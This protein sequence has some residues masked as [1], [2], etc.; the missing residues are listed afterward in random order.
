[1]FYF[2]INEEMLADTNRFPVSSDHWH[3]IDLPEEMGGFKVAKFSLMDNNGKFGIF[4]VEMH[5]VLSAGSDDNDLHREFKSAVDMV[6]KILGVELKCP[7]LR[8]V[9]E[10]R[11]HWGRIIDGPGTLPLSSQLRIEL[12]DSYSVNIEAKDA[13]YVKRNGKLHIVANATI[14]VEVRNNGASPIRGLPRRLGK[15]KKPVANAHEIAFGTDL[16]GPLSEAVKETAEERNGMRRS[17]HSLKRLVKQAESGDVEAAKEL[18]MAYRHG[19]GVKADQNLVFKYSKMAADAGDVGGIVDLADCYEEGHGTKKDVVKAAELWKKG[20]EMG[21]AWAVLKYAECLAEGKV[22]DPDPKEAVRLFTMCATHKPADSSAM[23]WLASCHLRGFGVEKD[24]AK[25]RE[26]LDK[27][28]AMAEDGDGGTIF[29]LANFFMDGWKGV[30]KDA[31]K[32]FKIAQL[33]EKTD[34]EW[35]YKII[36]RCYKDGIGVEKNAAKAKEYVEKGLGKCKN[37][38]C[39]LDDLKKMQKELEGE[40]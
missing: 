13:T 15:G 40:Q 18:V 9:E 27:A 35:G 39:N 29:L 12:A 19:L 24:E 5:K 4:N 2:V 32:A 21:N 17:V 37:G 7:E 6:G 25:A 1:M 30:G 14:E 33:A 8:E 28:E 31:L 36:A 16:S 34:T 23:V 22:V 26:W 3:E 11:G 10:W 20:A 38:N